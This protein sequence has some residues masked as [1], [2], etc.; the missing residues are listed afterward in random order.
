MTSGSTENQTN[1][2]PTFNNSLDDPESENCAEHRG[3]IRSEHVCAGDR[4][5]LREVG[6]DAGGGLTARK[7]VKYAPKKMNAAR[8]N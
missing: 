3:D 1:L 4:A 6:A 5:V 7:M 8:Q 2:N